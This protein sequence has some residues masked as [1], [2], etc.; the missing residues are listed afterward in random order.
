ML[1][2]TLKNLEN[3]NAIYTPSYLVDLRLGLQL[4][5]LRLIWQTVFIQ[6]AST[7]QGFKSHVHSIGDELLFFKLQLLYFYQL[8]RRDT[9]C[10][11]TLQIF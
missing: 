4:I 2:Y 3:T 9:I 6:I 8:T 1:F 5:K 11:K 7:T 10:V